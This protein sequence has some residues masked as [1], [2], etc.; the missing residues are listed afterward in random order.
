M[1]LSWLVRNKVFQTL[2]VSLPSLISS[3]VVGICI[4]QILGPEG[5]GALGLI[6]FNI[7]LFVLILG[8]SIGSAITYFIAN[9]KISAG[10]IMTISLFVIAAGAIIVGAT[11]M[12]SDWLGYNVIIYSEEFLSPT[13]IFYFFLIYFLTIFKHISIAFLQGFH[14]ITWINR[15]TLFTAIINFLIIVPL[16][17]YAKY[18]GNLASKQNFEI[19]IELLMIANVIAAL[20]ILYYLKKA[21][22][23]KGLKPVGFKLKDDFFPLMRF[24]FIGHLSN[25]VNFFNYRVDIWF[26]SF[27]FYAQFDTLSFYL[28]A[29]TLSQIIWQI[30]TAINLVY[31]PRLCENP[32]ISLTIRIS[33]LNTFLVSVVSIIGLLV[34]PYLIPKLYG[35][36]FEASIFPFQLLLIGIFFSSLSKTIASFIFAKGKV[37]IN[38][39]A[40]IVGL[41]V[42][43]VLDYFLIPVYGIV[44]AAWATN[45]TYFSIFLVCLTYIWIVAKKEGRNDKVLSIFVPGSFRIPTE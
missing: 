45:I 26:I 17:I 15:I 11:Y 34:A 36:K 4:V 42:T 21:I 23:E 9:K 32:S 19:V 37:N 18:G 40:T 28:V 1:K 27:F 10:K 41:L 35:G 13:V 31:F 24:A 44:G 16:F 22:H 14:K 8:L 20:P 7:E 2:M 38:L 39:I 33:R 43:L 3:F 5:K 6:S 29:V 30:P 25:V 12:L